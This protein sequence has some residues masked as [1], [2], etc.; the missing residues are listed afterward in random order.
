MRTRSRYTFGQWY[1]REDK[2]TKL[3]LVLVLHLN[4]SLS[5]SKVF[6]KPVMERSISVLPNIFGTI[7]NI[8]CVISLMVSALDLRLSGAGSSSGMEHSVVFFDKALYSQSATDHSGP[9]CLKGDKAV[10]RINH[11]PVDSVVCLVN[12]YSLDSDFPGVE[13]YPAFQQLGR[14]V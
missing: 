11:C 13:R 5:A 12:T 2:L 4:A 14:E 10:H 7:T 8:K 9:G 1:V 6:L 3:R